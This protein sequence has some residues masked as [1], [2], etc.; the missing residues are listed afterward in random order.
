MIFRLRYYLCS[1]I[2]LCQ[3]VRNLPAVLW[4][5]GRRYGGGSD[6]AI[7]VRLAGGYQFRVRSALDVWVLKE[8]LL[9]REYEHLG[10]PISQGGRSSTLVRPMANSRFLPHTVWAA[11]G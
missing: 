9:E 5:L 3:G 10:P 11:G 4:A 6:R 1:I 7:L 8:V 2:T